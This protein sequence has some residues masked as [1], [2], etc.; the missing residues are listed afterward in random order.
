MMYGDKIVLDPDNRPVRNFQEI[1]LTVSSK[2]EG[3]LMEAIRRQNHQITPH[4]FR[5]RMPRDPN[6][7]DLRD[8][9]G[10]WT[11]P[12]DDP[13]C[14]PG[15]LDMRMTRWR[16]KHRCIAWTK[17][18]GSKELKADLWGKMTDEQKIANSTEGMQDA[19][20][21]ELQSIQAINKGKY[22][23]R[24][25]NKKVETNNGTVGGA[26][27][28]YKPEGDQS[29]VEDPR[30]NETLLAAVGPNAPMRKRGRDVESMAEKS[31]GV[32]LE[33]NQP[34]SKRARYIDQTI[35]EPVNEGSNSNYP[36]LKRGRDI[37]EALE[38][39][40]GRYSDLGQPAR[41]R[42]R[43]MPEVPQE[44][45]SGRKNE[46]RQ[47]RKKGGDM[48]RTTL[49]GNGSGFHGHPTGSVQ[50]GHNAFGVPSPA[51]NFP[52]PSFVPALPQYEGSQ[53]GGVAGGWTTANGPELYI[54]ASRLQ[55]HNMQSNVSTPSFGYPQYLHMGNNY[56]VDQFGN[57][58]TAVRQLGGPVG[59][60]GP[61]SV[62][63]NGLTALPF[64]L[65]QP[66]H[67]NNP[68]IP[69]GQWMGG[70]NTNG[71]E[72]A[73][74]GQYHGYGSHMGTDHLGHSASAVRF[75]DPSLGFYGDSPNQVEHPGYDSHP[76]I[77]FVQLSGLNE[78]SSNTNFENGVS[79]GGYQATT[80]DGGEGWTANTI[81]EQGGL[82]SLGSGNPNYSDDSSELINMSELVGDFSQSGKI[83]PGGDLNPS[84]GDP[85]LSGDLDWNGDL[86]LSG[87]FNLDTH[88]NVNNG[89]NLGEGE[90]A[91]DDSGHGNA[92]V[93]E[94]IALQ[95][96]LHQPQNNSPIS[97]S[98]VTNFSEID[99]FNLMFPPPSPV[100]PLLEQGSGSK[101]GFSQHLGASGV[102][103]RNA[104]QLQANEIEN[105]SDGAND[106]GSGV[107]DYY[108]EAVH[109]PEEIIQALG[110]S[111]W[112]PMGSQHLQ[113]VAL[114]AITSPT[115]PEEQLMENYSIRADIETGVC[116][117]LNAQEDETEAYI[118]HDP[119]FWDGRFEAAT[120]FEPNE[121]EIPRMRTP[122]PTSS[123][124]N[125]VSDTA[126]VSE[127][128][129]LDS[130]F[131]EN[132]DTTGVSAESA[133]SLSLSDKDDLDS[134]FEEKTDTAG[135]NEESA[136]S[137]RVFDKELESFLRSHL[138]STDMSG[139]SAE[140][141]SVSDI[142]M[143]LQGYDWND[144]GTLTTLNE[145]SDGKDGLDPLG[146]DPMYL[147]RMR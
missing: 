58:V 17:K 65:Q 47:S 36:T 40:G 62:T 48:A 97:T 103:G 38:A 106:E 31:S 144:L 5:A 15:A 127:E 78:G 84:S 83:N 79:F 88:F 63:S 118:E 133:G 93:E 73:H 22:M 91:V 43:N 80:H 64:G 143:T 140:S 107:Q 75:P 68:H 19:D 9:A 26:Q 121:M 1:P 20:N 24:S 146:F 39:D 122:E 13:L 89:P 10:N 57:V 128:D 130:L 108:G 69:T 67:I 113:E 76:N 32:G 25:K 114:Q 100:E 29:R 145:L 129:D 23:Q 3:W 132:T 117:R 42:S 44:I 92:V 56:Y 125:K 51:Y 70:R 95:P 123:S 14:T 71:G 102:K 21:Q 30:S 37:E 59:W 11:G 131:E 72:Q 41:K 101:D 147:H 18:A 81:G 35:E 4:D 90:F 141:P 99:R 53:M 54:P 115:A 98:N 134:L 139:E 61:H 16:A 8:S 82:S 111:E 124:S 55:S 105:T 85:D 109:G 120:N 136:G 34:M 119:L 50:Y 28:Q 66:Q 49:M 94:G 52:A 87:D 86:D 96:N 116:Q 138:K 112:E 60:A 12:D 46:Q 137:L 33:S 74:G 126:R 6:G 135:V 142:D 27:G 45:R 110:T 7:T 77:P 2:V 104:R